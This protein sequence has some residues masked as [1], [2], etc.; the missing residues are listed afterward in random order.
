ML[1]DADLPD[2][3]HLLHDA[4]LPPD[5]AHLGGR[6]AVLRRLREE[7]AALPMGRARDLAAKQ[8]AELAEIEHLFA[9]LA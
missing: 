7:H 2:G 3:A 1:H 6:A 9:G 8:V 4:D 5:A